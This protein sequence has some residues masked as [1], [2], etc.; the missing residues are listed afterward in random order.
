M[1]GIC[2]IS[3][4]FTDNS[5]RDPLAVAQLKAQQIAA[6]KKPHSASALRQE[7]EVEAV[8]TSTRSPA[9]S[10]LALIRLTVCQNVDLSE[11]DP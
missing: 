11:A 5:H 10:P 8:S 4:R 3:G 9:L 6:R 1:I 7:Q 2:K